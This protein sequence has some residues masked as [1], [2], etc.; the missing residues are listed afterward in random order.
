MKKLLVWLLNFFKSHVK[1]TVIAG[2]VLIL[3]GLFFIMKHSNEKLVIDKAKSEQKVI[4]LEN[5]KYILIQERDLQIAENNK[6]K[7][8]E[9]SIKKEKDKQAAYYEYVIRKNKQ[10][11]DSLMNIPDDTVFIRLQPIFPNTAQEPLKYPFSG[12]QIRQVYSMALSYPALK[13]EYGLQTTMLNT[14][15]L[16]NKKYEQTELNYIAQIN[17]LGSQVGIANTQLGEKDKQIKI[18]E[19][20]LNR[21]TFWNWTQK[22]VIVAAVIKIVFFK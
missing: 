20:Q 4:D 18:T 9:D 2:L 7:A 11:I 13:Q 10:K 15:D 16:L 22:W 19:K 3:I 17:N 12:S 14:C 6:L 1:E 8:Q 5:Q 21:K